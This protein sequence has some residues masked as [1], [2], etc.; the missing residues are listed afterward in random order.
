M[1]IKKC[2]FAI[3]LILGVEKIFEKQVTAEKEH[4]DFYIRD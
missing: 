2:F 3:L 4:I 1:L